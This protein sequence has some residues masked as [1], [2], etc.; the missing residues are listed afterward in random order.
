MIKRTKRILRKWNHGLKQFLWKLDH[1]SLYRA[2]RLETGKG[3]QI[4]QKTRITGKGKVIIGDRCSFG[5]KPGGFYFGPG[6]ELQPRYADAVIKVGNDVH[7]NNNIFICAARLI[8][9]GNRV[10][11]GQGV[12]IMDFEAHDTSPKNRNRLGVIKPVKIEYNVWIG[13]NVTILKGV[14][15]GENTVVASNAVVT[16][17]FPRNSIIGGVPAK[18]IGKVE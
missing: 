14:V 15:I 18:I 12:I 17:S 6:I 3:L 1:D 9:I 8:E 5:F 13:N 16:K 2:K 7:S 11:V 10:L 4:I